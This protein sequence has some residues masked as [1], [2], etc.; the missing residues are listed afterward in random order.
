MGLVCRR[1]AELSRGVWLSGGMNCQFSIIPFI[2][3]NRLG[4]TSSP[5][6]YNGDSMSERRLEA[7]VIGPGKPGF[8]KVALGCGQGQFVADVPFERLEPSLRVP[9]SHFVAVVE[10]RE[11]VR[12]EP[13]GRIWLTIQD[14]IRSVLNADWDPIGVVGD[15]INDEYDSYIGRIYSLLLSGA[16]EQDIAQHLLSIEVDWMG[17]TGTP[18]DQLRT[19]AAMLIK[20]QLPRV[21]KPR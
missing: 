21:Q 1:S 11:L 6:S 2:R 4:D 14:E 16:S 7:A 13:A 10:G 3:A 12:V 9:N 20:L 8:L 17:L 19:V 15:G 18:M 5:Q